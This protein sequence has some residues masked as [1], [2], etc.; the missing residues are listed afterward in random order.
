MRIWGLGGA[1]FQGLYYS[2]LLSQPVGLGYQRARLW[3]LRT[4]LDVAELRLS[5][6]APLP[7]EDEASVQSAP[8]QGID[9]M[10]GPDPARWAF[11]SPLGWAIGV[12][13][14]GA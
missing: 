1:P 6:Y 10:L 11:P 4:R 14:F 9:P 12:R 2:L 7:L 13:A 8:F 3:R 5:A